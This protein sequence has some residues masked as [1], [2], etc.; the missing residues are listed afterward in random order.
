MHTFNYDAI[1]RDMAVELGH[2]VTKGEDLH[3][4]AF[5]VAVGS[6]WFAYTTFHYKILDACKVDSRKM[7]EE[8]EI[9]FSEGFNASV[10][11]M[12]ILC[13]YHDMIDAYMERD[14]K[15]A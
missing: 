4:A 11:R 5:S 10:S 12:V 15:N 8:R 9:G 1:I 2:R 6:K 14:P 3:T 7:A 13:L